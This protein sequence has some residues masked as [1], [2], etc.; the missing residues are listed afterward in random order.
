MHLSISKEKSTANFLSRGLFHHPERICGGRQVSWL[1]AHGVAGDLPGMCRFF[2]KVHSLP[3]SKHFWEGINFLKQLNV[4]R[5]FWRVFPRPSAPQLQWRVRSGFI[6]D[7]LFSPK[8]F[9]FGAPA[10]IKI[11]DF[12]GQ[13]FCLSNYTMKSVEKQVFNERETFKRIL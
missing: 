12:K 9:P 13:S 7:F 2:Q 5:W 8:P 10:P 3:P 4:F 1:M 6:P 11:F